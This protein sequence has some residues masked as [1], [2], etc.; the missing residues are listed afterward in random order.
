MAD[1]L[2]VAAIVL[3]AATGVV[4]MASAW[5]IVALVVLLARQAP[6]PLEHPTFIIATHPTV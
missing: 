2:M 5:T 1:L 4:L 6:L 3:M